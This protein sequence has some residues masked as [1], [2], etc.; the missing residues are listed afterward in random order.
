MRLSAQFV[1]LAFQCRPQATGVLRLEEHIRP[2]SQSLGE[3]VI[4]LGVPI[5]IVPQALAI[6]QI[7]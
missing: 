3:E 7:E 4:G 5:D 6:E 1:S 2:Q